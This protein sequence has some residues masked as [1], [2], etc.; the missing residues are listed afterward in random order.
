MTETGVRL[1][2]ILA[3]VRAGRRGEALARWIHGL[4]AARPDVTA[5][6]LDLGDWALP[7]YAHEESP[8]VAEK[9]FAPGSVERRWAEKI[10]SL[11]GYV[12]VTPEYNHGYPSALKSALDAV[13]APWNHKPVAFVS[14]GG[15]ASGA[16]AV[17]QLRLVAI[18]LRMVPV[19]DEVNVRLVGYAAD[20]RGRPADPVYAKK[21]SAMIDDLLWWTRVAKEGRER[22][23]R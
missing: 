10:A 2:V 14:Y 21:A 12:I 1:G 20:E 9:G 15:F 7:A 22:R 17:E 13:Y 16:R 4:V 3:S 11:D 8:N 18:E 19:R 6:L 23:P 5:E